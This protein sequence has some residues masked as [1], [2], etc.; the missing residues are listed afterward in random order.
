M[1]LSA[2]F[3]PFQAEQEFLL[4][5]VGGADFTGV[6]KGNRTLCAMAELLQTDTTEQAMTAALRR[7]YDAPPGVI[8][9]DVTVLLD[10]LR[11][12]GALEE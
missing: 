9:A 3:I 11:A 1:K 8:E 12:V 10:R 5:P 2:D 4:V 7:R 6:V